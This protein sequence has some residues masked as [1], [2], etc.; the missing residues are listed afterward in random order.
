[1]P[2]KKKLIYILGTMRSGT[3]LLCSLL[4][5]A[6]GAVAVGEPHQLLRG[7]KQHYIC[8][9]GN[10]LDVC[11]FW[12]PIFS[13]HVTRDEFA[14]LSDSLNLFRPFV[15]T[16]HEFLAL[17]GFKGLISQQVLDVL[18]RFY[19]GI[20]EVSGASVIIDDSKLLNHL[21]L[22]RELN[23]FDIYV[24]HLVR[25]PRAVAF[26]WARKKETRIPGR[27]MVTYPPFVSAGKWFRVHLLNLLAHG[28]VDQDH[29]LRL[30]Y[31]D[32]AQNPQQVMEAI[33][34]K[35]GLTSQL[36]FDEQN[37]F[38]ANKDVHLLFS[39]SSSPQKGINH[40]RF[41]SEYKRK[42]SWGLK[43][44]VTFVCWPLMVLFGYR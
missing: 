42:A 16:L 5:E 8:S 43:A 18:R 14:I 36:V 9:C 11:D 10:N 44:V 41:D 35:F 27:F 4:G 2:E 17:V 31:E 34:N 39:N 40:V 23:L 22:L 21:F 26:S 32:L 38:Y 28:F 29:F 1:M 6:N 19:E 20:Y 7:R 15:T 13:S 37:D 33:N 12:K 25:D 24:I 3:T 30:R